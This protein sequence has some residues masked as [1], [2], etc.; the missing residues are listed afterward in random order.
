LNIL[1]P[2]NGPCGLLACVI[3]SV[4]V[5]R[6]ERNQVQQQP[7]DREITD[8]ELQQVVYR[9]IACGSK[10]A[11]V[12]FNGQMIT[13]PA[14]LPVNLLKG[15]GSCI[16]IIQACIETRGADQIRKDVA[17][18]HGELPLIVGPNALC[19]S[20]LMTLLMKGKAD[21]NF[22]AGSFDDG[23][24]GAVKAS[25]DDEWNASGFGMLTFVS[26]SSSSA[27]AV[28]PAN[29][30]MFPKWPVWVLHGGDHFTVLIQI[31]AT[32]F[33]HLNGLPPAGP[34]TCTLQIDYTQEAKPVLRDGS[35][36]IVGVNTYV[37]PIPGE[38]DEIVQANPQD[39]KDF[40][41]DWTKWRIEVV[42]AVDDPTV[43]DD[44][45]SVGN[46]GGV[47]LEPRQVKIFQLTNPPSKLG[48]QWRCAACYR[49]RF[50]TMNFGLQQIQDINSGKCQHCQRPI[51]EAGWSLWF[52]YQELPREVQIRVDK[53]FAPKL[54]N[55]IRSRWLDAQIKVV[56]G[57]KWDGLPST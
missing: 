39:K 49:D 29:A 1:Q 38:I 4:A 26:S 31:K 42:L 15:K 3:A 6:H 37:K 32:Q 7:I 5:L 21:G 43:K 35:R 57:N 51:K 9:I 24:G 10:K 55:V 53:M 22:S 47:K 48:E 50:K 19:S 52:P 34:R 45:S 46:S 16:R 56:G 12:K 25:S 2:K 40:T 14:D 23:S 20:E 27:I 11:A 28:Q 8:E 33:L 17:S 13:K 30:L 41:D 44:V 18:T 36:P 54:V